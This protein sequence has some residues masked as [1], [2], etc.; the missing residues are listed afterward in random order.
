ML[1]LARADARSR[2]ERRVPRARVRQAAARQRAA[3]MHRRSG[4]D[5]R[6]TG[7]LLLV[8]AGKSPERVDRGVADAHL[9]VEVR[10]GRMA[11]RTDTAHANA[12]RDPDSD[13]YVDAREVRVHRPLAASV[14]DD[15][16]EAP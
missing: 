11:P 6:C 15:D 5:G 13:P 2:D 3:G 14:R 1:F 4:E 12:L 9:E 7:D 16:E 10:A 8:L